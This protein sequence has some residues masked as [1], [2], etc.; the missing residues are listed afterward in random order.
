MTQWIGLFLILPTAVD[1]S[2][3]DISSHLLTVWLQ[4]TFTSI[5]HMNN[6]VEL[7]IFNSWIQCCMD[8]IIGTHLLTALA[9]H[10]CFCICE[11]MSQCVQT[12]IFVC[13]CACG[14]ECIVFINMYVNMW[15]YIYVHVCM[16]AHMCRWHV[17]VHDCTNMC[18]SMIMH[19]YVY[20]YL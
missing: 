8:S 1:T 6:A 20:A 17:S 3:S 19:M 9:R 2:E 12:C 10:V 11:C 5:L 18:E 16:C 15:K 7:V 4:S 14:F 13:E